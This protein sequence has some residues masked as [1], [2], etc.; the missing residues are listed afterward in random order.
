MHYNR[1]MKASKC[2]MK[3]FSNEIMA[4]TCEGM[5][6]I[7]PKAINLTETPC[8]INAATSESQPSLASLELLSDMTFQKS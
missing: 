2:P 5:S 8:G 7:G 4:Y 6:D 1:T 3:R